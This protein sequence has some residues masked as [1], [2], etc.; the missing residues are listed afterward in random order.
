ML[1]S[2]KYK[3]F[4]FAVSISFLSACSN[5]KNKISPST[6][7]TPST[8]STKQTQVV[9]LKALQSIETM[10]VKLAKH[11]VVFVGESHTNYGDHLNQLAVIKN[12]HKHW[13][14]QTSIGL[15]MVQQPYQSFLDQYIAGE[16]SEKDL[17]R[18]IEW[19]DRWM[20]DFRLYRPIFNYAKQHRIPLVALNI[21]KELTKRITKVGI[22]KL[23][24]KERQQLPAVIYR[25]NKQ[26]INRIKQV[27][28]GH[29]HTSSKGFEKFLDAQLGWDEG[30]AYAAAKYL[31]K[32]PQKHM[33]IIAG[34]G[35]II[36]YEGIPSRLDRQIHSKSAVI[37]NDTQAGSLE[38]AGDYLL[39]SEEQE[40]PTKGLFGI[41]M[42]DA[43]AENKKAKGVII[44]MLSQHGAAKK[45]GLKKG[46][47]IIGLNKQAVQDIVDIRLFAEKTKPGSKVA[48]KIKR[49]NKV[50]MLQAT[51]K[52]KIS[53][54]MMPM[55]HK[56]K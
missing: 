45:A 43:S 8:P 17:L 46:D 20:F 56:K 54:M 11:R 48:I 30:M 40:L 6:S 36:N 1:T 34:S 28:G 5:T 21:P 26:Y 3:L 9:D 29:S 16:I 27:F 50:K 2:N 22:N 47:I 25:S 7:S 39:F 12:L 24:K 32:H 13:G 44:T 10:S 42:K 55:I 14:K 51:L 52:S 19:Y 23:S 4:L 18:G 41:G 35:H 15:E 33:I 31:K 49:H 38:N 37:L 53:G